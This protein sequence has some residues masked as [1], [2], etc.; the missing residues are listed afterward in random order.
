MTKIDKA[1]VIFIIAT[2]PLWIVPALIA[3]G[4]TAILVLLWKLGTLALIAAL[5]ITGKH[6]AAARIGYDSGWYE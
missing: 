2:F 4:L 3:A 5:E 1:G 6:K